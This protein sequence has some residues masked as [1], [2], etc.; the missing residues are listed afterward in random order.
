[1][2]MTSKFVA[3]AMSKGVEHTVYPI[4]DILGPTALKL[5][6]GLIHFCLDTCIIDIGFRATLFCYKF[7]V[8]LN[9][10]YRDP[11]VSLIIHW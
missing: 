9:C 10:T 6:N 4:F 5:I 7:E 3:M 11:T 1:M 8:E 2:R